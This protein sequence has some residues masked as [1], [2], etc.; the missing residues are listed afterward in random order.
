MTD[1]KAAGR[2]IRQLQERLA[3]HEAKALVAR[4][5]VA[6]DRVVVVEALD[7]WDAAGLKAL[8]SAAAEVPG[9]AVALF[10][11]TTPALVVVARAKDVS[12][13]AGAVVKALA[14]SFGGRGGGKP[15]LAQAGALTGAPEDLVRT[16]RE[17]LGAES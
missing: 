17:L 5:T 14:T 12:L 9:V 10:S 16:A 8:A 3:A 13:D 11:T 4:G 1:S 2:T 15:D 6:G 7:G